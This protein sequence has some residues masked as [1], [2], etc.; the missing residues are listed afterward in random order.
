ML[1]RRAK[2]GLKAALALASSR[3]DTTVRIVDLA[4]AEAIP[5]KFL[6]QILLVLK[7]CG[8]LASRKGRGGGYALA[9]PA[10][11]I[12][13][14]EVIR[15]LDGPLAPTPCVSVNFYKR[16][17]ECVDEGRCAIRPVMKQARDAIA[18]ILDNT[19]LE[20]ALGSSS[21]RDRP[22]CSVPEGQSAASRRTD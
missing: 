17:P 19:T 21:E 8:I 22:Q 5:R 16:C 9:R 7:D 12:T 2:Y 18:A 4:E 10:N 11:T 13:F 1:T 6:E 3:P 15:A 20:T 14:G